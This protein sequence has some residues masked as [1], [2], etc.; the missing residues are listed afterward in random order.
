MTP[1]PWLQAL[2]RALPLALLA[3]ALGVAVALGIRSPRGRLWRLVSAAVA[4]LALAT[5]GPEAFEQLGLLAAPVALL[6]FALPALVERW[7]A[8]HAAPT[9][10]RDC[11]HAP[12]CPHA[13]RPG[14][15][16]TFAVLLAHRLF[17][18][19]AAVALDP[20]HGGSLH[21]DPLPLLLLHGVPV[22]LPV[23]IGLRAQRGRLMAL[24]RS[25]WLGLAPLLGA[26]TMALPAVADALLAAQPWSAALLLGV[27]GHGVVHPAGAP[28]AHHRHEHP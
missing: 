3:P 23:L 18:G 14:L 12:D 19:L 2:L 22:M 8:R 4:L 5:L 21:A 6:G 13:E 20:H 26:S 11:E 27:L 15:D 17:D 9:P 16:A 24:R 25:L 1:T 28:H 7:A 10:P